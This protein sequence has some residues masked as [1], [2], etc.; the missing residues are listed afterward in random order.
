MMDIP[1][2]ER[3]FIDLKACVLVPTYNN[4]GTLATVLRDV[5]QYTT[6]VIVVNDGSTDD[7]ENILE[8]F[9]Q[10]HIVSYKPNAGKGMALRRGFKEAVKLGYEHAITLDSDGQH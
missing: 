4:A 7:T 2:Y 5:L 9:P 8:G 6:Q 3:R 1:V 10:V